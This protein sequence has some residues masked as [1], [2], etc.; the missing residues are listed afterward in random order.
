MKQ[1]YTL[2]KKRKFKYKKMTIKFHINMLTTFEVF[3]KG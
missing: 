3:F 1:G 2:K